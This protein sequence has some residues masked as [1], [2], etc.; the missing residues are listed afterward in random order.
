M[1]SKRKTAIIS[2]VSGKIA[3]YSNLDKK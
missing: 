2:C 1:F 3:S